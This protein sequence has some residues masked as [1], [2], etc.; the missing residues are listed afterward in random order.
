MATKS[1][2][3]IGSR[4]LVI[5]LLGALTAGAGFAEEAGSSSQDHGKGPDL[6]A[7]PGGAPSPSSEDAASIPGGKNHD[8]IDT[9][10]SV[11]PRHPAAKADK[12]GEAKSKIKLPLVKNLHRR[13]FSASGASNRTARNAIAVPITEH[14]GM[15]RQQ[16]EHIDLPTALHSPAGTPGIVENNAI[17][18]A[19]PQPG[20]ARPIIWPPNKSPIVGPIAVT[21]GISGA[22]M[23]RRGVGPAGLGGPAKTVAGINGTTVRPNR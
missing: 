1:G 19:K 6:S 21:H 18:L 22:S 2:L 5:A 8:D 11:Q 13:T 10:M 9:R 15:A 12:V 4:L 16:G 20:L 14:E 3:R 17:G 7:E 23:G